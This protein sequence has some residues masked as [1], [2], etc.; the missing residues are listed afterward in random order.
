[1]AGFDLNLITTFVT[2]YET[3]S[4]TL[5]ADRLCVTQPSVSYAL[6]KLRDQFDDALFVR[7][8]HGMQ[9]TRLATQLYGGFKD[10]SRSIDTAVSEARK[11][12]PATSR[13]NFRLAL[14]D[15]GE[16]ALLPLVLE[17]LNQIAP[18]IELEVVP[19]EIDQVSAWLNDGH[20]DAAICSRALQGAGIVHHRL[21]SEHYCCLVD[22]AHPRIGA[23]MSMEQFLAELHVIV[24][25]TSGHGMAEDVLQKMGAERRV[26]LR[27]PHFS[28]LP[29]IIPGT[30]MITIL[31]TRIARSFCE[32]PLAKPLKVVD[33]PFDVPPFEVTLHWHARSE[34]ST[35]LTWFCKQIEVA[36][37]EQAP[38]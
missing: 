4:V 37:G 31:P 16:M 29:K 12:A 20:I 32:Q 13:R 15:L 30:E 7:N 8:Q 36:L 10:A 27:I 1:M 19:L 33:L 11:F 18:N 14:S 22:E 3:Q 24:T 28:V 6:A 2:L 25:R 34:K 26:R 17:R 38:A 5:T 35:A 9:P 21:M 23:R